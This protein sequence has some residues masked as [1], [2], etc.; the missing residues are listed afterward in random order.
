MAAGGD[1]Q[2]CT[3]LAAVVADAAAAGRRLVVRGSGSKVFYGNAVQGETL[4]LDGVRGIV[5]YVP[6]ELYLTAR[7]AT[8]LAE[9]RA[10]L[11]EKGQELP[12]DPPQFGGGGTFGGAIAAGLAGPAKPRSGG[13]RDALLGVQIINGKGEV[14]NFGGQVVKNVAGYDVSRLMA[15]S[16]GT[17]GIIT[18]AT[19]KVLPRAPLSCTVVQEVDAADAVAA[20]H[21]YVQR[22]LPLAGSFYQDGKLFVRFAGGSVEW[23]AAQTGASTRLPPQEEAAFWQQVRDHA[24]PF[25]QQREQPLWRISLPP[26]RRAAEV[27]HPL[28][29]SGAMVLEWNGA[30]YWQVGGEAAAVRAQAQDLGGYACLFRRNAALQDEAFLPPPAP[31][32]QRLHRRLK[33]AFDPA[34]ILNVGRV[35]A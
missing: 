17:L 24:L 29:V 27:Y 22:S 2:E 12:F 35:Y 26:R 18:Q 15:G 7:A 5:E 11:A 23:A 14:L 33:E 28:L 25:F 21:G 3:T 4:S 1:L 10:V 8:P 19:V 34:N 20:V 16:L 9:V 6:E 32:Q 13:V 30:V 31:V